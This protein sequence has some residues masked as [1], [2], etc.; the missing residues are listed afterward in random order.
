MNA[1]VP[2]EWE[3]LTKA[4]KQ[5]VINYCLS[6]LREQE[7][8]DMRIMLELFIKMNCALIHDLFGFGEKRLNLYIGN[9]QMMFREQA[10]FVS[11]GKQLESL[12]KRM[13]KI[14]RKKGFP[15]EFVDGIIGK[16]DKDA[17]DGNNVLQKL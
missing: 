10:R 6:V 9:F 16:V 7:D 13:K 12:D 3:N 4:Q 14:F 11:K 2:R 5:K 15:Q 1:R 17:L 8:K